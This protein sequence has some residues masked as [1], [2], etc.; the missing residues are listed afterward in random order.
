MAGGMLFV[1]GDQWQIDRIHR[2]SAVRPG[3]FLLFFALC[4]M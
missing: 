1:S 3:A 2:G 4:G